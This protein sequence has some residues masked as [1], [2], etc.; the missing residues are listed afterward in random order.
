M[1]ALHWKDANW[2]ALALVPVSFL[3]PT[4]IWTHLKHLVTN[5]K[6]FDT[7]RI[8]WEQFRFKLNCPVSLQGEVQVGKWSHSSWVFLFLSLQTSTWLLGPANTS[9]LKSNLTLSNWPIE[10]GFIL[11]FS[12]YDFSDF[13][14]KAEPMTSACIMSFLTRRP[15]SYVRSKHTPLNK[16]SFWWASGQTPSGDITARTFFENS[17]NKT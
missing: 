1:L 11:P 2:R 8:Q 14:L 15:T 4:D 6:W 7:L 5:F 9:P 16:H 3:Q 10:T 13:W 17:T 12:T